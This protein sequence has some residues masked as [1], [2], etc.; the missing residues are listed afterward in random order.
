VAA[1]AAALVPRGYVPSETR[2]FARATLPAPAN[3]ALCALTVSAAGPVLVVATADRKLCA[4]SW[5]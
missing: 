5:C 3:P 4:F 1:K 2:D